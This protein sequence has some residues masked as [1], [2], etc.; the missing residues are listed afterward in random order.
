M[1]RTSIVFL[2]AIVVVVLFL[3]VSKRDLDMASK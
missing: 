1:E 2:V 3:T